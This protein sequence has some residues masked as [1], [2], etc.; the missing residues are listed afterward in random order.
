MLGVAAIF[1]YGLPDSVK[2]FAEMGVPF[3]TLSNYDV[4]IGVAAQKGY[5]KEEVLEGLKQWKK[6]PRDESW[7][8]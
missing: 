2:N 5:I 7:I 6:D 8:K 1:T 3:K 4:L